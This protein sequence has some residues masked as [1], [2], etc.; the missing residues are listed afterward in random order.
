M[1]AAL[2]TLA[3]AGA[4]FTLCY[5]KSKRPIG[6]A[7]QEQ[8]H[9]Y[10]EA[11]AHMQRGGNVGLLAGALS[12]WLIAIDLDKRAKDFAAQHPHVKP[13]CIWRQNAPDRAKFIVRAEGARNRKDHRAGLEIISFGNAIVTGTHESGAA[14]Q[15]ACRGDVPVL[16]VAEVGAIFEAWTGTPYDAPPPQRQRKN[17]DPLPALAPNLPPST[18]FGARLALDHLAPWRADDYTE[19]VRIGMVLKSTHGD[20]AYQLWDGWSQRSSKYPGA[21]ATRQKWESFHP[22]GR[23]SA[24]TISFLVDQDNAR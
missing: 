13:W 16:T 18:L 21:D 5:Q 23:L 1:T 22:D 19:W 2:R 4:V 3:D 12:A 24:G 8:P 17:A 20:A 7:W 9:G 6:D 15:L 10:E 11:A 14:V